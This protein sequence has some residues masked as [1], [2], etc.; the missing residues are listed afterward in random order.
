MTANRRRYS[1]YFAGNLTRE[2]KADGEHTVYT[3][4][5]NRLT[6][7]NCQQGNVGYTEQRTYLDDGRIATYDLNGT[8][9]GY[10]YNTTQPHTLRNIHTLP[11]RASDVLFSFAWDA[12]GKAP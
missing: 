8:R 12:K 9:Q 6:A 3:Y 7:T 1:N 4:S 11:N 5:Y 10:S 2:Q